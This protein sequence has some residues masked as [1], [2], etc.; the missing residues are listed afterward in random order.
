ML[1]FPLSPIRWLTT[2]P[3]ETGTNTVLRLYDNVLTSADCLHLATKTKTRSSYQLLR[4]VNLPTKSDTVVNNGP[5]GDRHQHSLKTR[6]SYQLL[7]HVNLPT[8]SNTVVNNGPAGDW[9]QHSLKAGQPYEGH[10][11]NECVGAPAHP[12]GRTAH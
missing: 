5:A 8:K 4:H 9:H 6:S 11:G 12:S 3:L 2:G 10:N 7:R 1:I